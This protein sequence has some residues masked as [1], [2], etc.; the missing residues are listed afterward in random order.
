MIAS[1]KLS[2]D[3]VF[4]NWGLPPQP[5]VWPRDI[6]LAVEFPGAVT[7]KSRCED[8]TTINYTVELKSSDVCPETAH[9]SLYLILYLV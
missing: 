9:G 4:I 5:C 3:L 2:L 6:D 7:A 8:G 1:V